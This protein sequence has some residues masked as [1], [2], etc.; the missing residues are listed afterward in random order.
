MPIAFP[1]LCTD[2]LQ[3]GRPVRFRAPGASMHPTIRD[4]EVVTVFP[5]PTREIKCGDVFLYQA[6][7]GLTAHRVIRRLP[8]PKTVFR[9]RGDAPG[10]EEERV[11]ADQVLGRVASVNR[12]GRD[13]PVGRS[14]RSGVGALV[15]LARRTR[16]RVVGLRG[17]SAPP[18]SVLPRLLMRM[19]QAARQSV[20]RVTGSLGIMWR[21]LHGRCYDLD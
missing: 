13:L 12:A 19:R 17:L 6:E 2:L 9:V 18:R 3:S 5:V 15:R 1:D 14:L 10:S 4:G 11:A 20:N 7:R 16:A 8:G 21:T